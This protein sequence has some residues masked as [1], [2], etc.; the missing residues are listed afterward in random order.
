MAE[1]NLEKLIEV[2]DTLAMVYK[3]EVVDEF[4]DNG[5]LVNL[6]QAII[7]VQN[8]MVSIAKRDK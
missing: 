1:T 7:H 2:R 4:H 6:H 5:N 8:A 3:K